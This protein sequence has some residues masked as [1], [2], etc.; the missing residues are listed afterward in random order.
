MPLSRPA[1]K[2]ISITVLLAAGLL[3]YCRPASQAQGASGSGG[4]VESAT[5]TA[6][7]PKLTPAQVAALLPASRGPFTFPA[8]YHTPAYRL[9]TPDDCGG[10]DCV[11]SVGYSYWATMNNS[12]GS[13]LLYAFV[14]LGGHGGPTLFSVDKATGAVRKIG[15]L[16]SSGDKLSEESG[17]GWYFSASRQT[18]L[19]VYATVST[20]LYRY[21]VLAR[22]RQTVF[23]IAQHFGADKYI[24]QVHSSHNDAVH[25]FTLRQNGSYAM[26]GCAVYDETKASFTYFPKRGDFDECQ[27]DQSG[28]YL[29]IKENVDGRN[30]EDNVVEDLQTGAEQVLLD[31]NGAGGHSDMGFG[32]MVAEDNWYK[33]PGATRLWFFDRPLTDASQGQLM[34]RAADWDN[35]SVSE[36]H[37]SHLNA[38]AGVPPAQQY[39]CSSH[40]TNANTPR[41]NE[42]YC[43]PLDG[44][45]R[46]LVVAPTM[47]DVDAAGG[48]DVYT[49][50]PKG[51]LDVTGQFFMWTSNMEGNGRRLD[52]FIVRVPAHLLTGVVSPHDTTAPSVALT[53]PAN[54]ATVQGAIALSATARDDVGIASVRFDLDGQPLG[55]ETSAGKCTVVWDT[56]RTPNGAHTLTAI[57][58]DTAGNSA[59]SAPRTITVQNAPA[60]PGSAPP[61]VDLSAILASS[62]P[63]CSPAPAAPSA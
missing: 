55:L 4:F 15:P 32:Y 21:D 35:T 25:S 62:P 49:K 40:A 26:L 16:F 31:E 43:Y 1:P 13:G 20:T 9:T 27:I 58:F 22:T 53:A 2:R 37:L 59:T 51:N 57:A 50:L 8:P 56:S 60:G 12:A 38:V 42:V 24:W 30:G 6:V 36:D 17:E 11:T 46:V 44:S 45:L 5:S 41:G 61:V 52:A 33:A 54:G 47:V 19:Y 39:V 29:L 10:T 28:R 34:N 48:S 18:S 3:T 23:D 14:T 63:G 7:R